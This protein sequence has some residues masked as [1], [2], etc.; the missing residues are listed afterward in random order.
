MSET[1]RPLPYITPLT[2]P[3]W[4]ATKAGRLEVQRCTACGHMRFPPSQVCED[5]LSEEAQWVQVSGRGTVWSVCEFHRQYFKGIDVP[6][7]VALVRLEEGPRMYTNIV[8]AAY[9]QIEPGMKVEAV[10]EPVTDGVTLLKFRP[11]P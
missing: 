4:D 6:Y 8:G 2:Q 10:F 9:D 7:N 1:A 11:V 3:F 5:C